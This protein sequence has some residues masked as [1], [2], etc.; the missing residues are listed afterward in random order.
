[1]ESR[2][3]KIGCRNK[4]LKTKKPSFF[5]SENEAA[6]QNLDLF[7]EENIFIVFVYSAINYQWLA[8]DPNILSPLKCW[9]FT[10]NSFKYVLIS[11]FYYLES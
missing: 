1:M 3:W 8:I 7:Q 9:T 11:F 6:I 10:F 2:I 5:S 4:W